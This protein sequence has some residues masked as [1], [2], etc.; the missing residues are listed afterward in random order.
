MSKA[1][2]YQIA[3]EIT[4]MEAERYLARAR[5]YL[6]GPDSKKY[7]YFPSRDRAAMK[8]ASMDLTRALVKVRR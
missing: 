6:D 2:D 4:V 8:R 3:V 7:S 5:A 1:T